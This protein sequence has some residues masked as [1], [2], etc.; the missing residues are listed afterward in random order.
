MKIRY[1]TLKRIL[2]EVAVS[3]SVFKNNQTVHDPMDR[4]S[5]AKA[6][7]S[8]EEPFRRGIIMNLTLEARDSYDEASGDFDDSAQARINSIADKATEMLMANVHKSVQRAW[9]EAMKGVAHT[10]AE[11]APESG[12]KV[13]A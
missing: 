6:V 4:P 8:I 11:V 1:G 13:A 5:I 7:A 3:A 10:G 2:R 9:A 12:K